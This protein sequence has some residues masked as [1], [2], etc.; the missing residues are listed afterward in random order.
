MKRQ[1]AAFLLA[2]AAIGVLP[3]AKPAPP[4]DGPDGAARQLTSQAWRS[5]GVPVCV[6]RLHTVRALTPDDLETIC[7]C[8]FDSYLE[9]HGAEPLPGLAN[10]QIPL[11]MEERLLRCTAE[12]RPD[13]A[14]A[15]AELHATYPQPVALVATGPAA[16]N[17]KPV[18]EADAGPAATS[19]GGGFW[20]WV[21]SITL[22]DWLTGAGIL[23]WIAIGIF[24]FGLLILKVRRRDPRNDLLGPPP[25]MRRGAPLQPPRRPDL[26]R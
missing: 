9:G 14:A 18:D 5:R 25:S 22:P 4:A 8:T 2:L 24:V 23:W 26:P 10:D 15:V 13:Q 11:A 21:R 16:D 1:A 6:A 12:T 17:P 19:S 20:D 7:G 3:A